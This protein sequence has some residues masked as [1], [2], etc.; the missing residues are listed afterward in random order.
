[1]GWS[2]GGCKEVCCLSGQLLGPEQ[3]KWALSIK[4]IFSHVLYILFLTNIVMDIA[5]LLFCEEKLL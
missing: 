2:Q 1:M 5:L 4:I 3:K